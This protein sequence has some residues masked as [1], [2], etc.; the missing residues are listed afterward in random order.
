MLG[1][2]SLQ[3]IQWVFMLV[4]VINYYLNNLY[5]Y[6]YICVCVSTDMMIVVLCVQ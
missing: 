2:I 1:G 6:T 4:I 3:L 5:V